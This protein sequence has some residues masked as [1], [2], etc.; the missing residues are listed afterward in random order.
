MDILKAKKTGQCQGQ[1]IQNYVAIHSKKDK[2]T[3]KFEKGAHC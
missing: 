1:K 3:R 2:R